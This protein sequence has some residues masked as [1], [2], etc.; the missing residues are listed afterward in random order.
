VSLGHW[1]TGVRALTVA[2]AL[3]AV[4]AQASAASTAWHDG[5]FDVQT[6]QVV[7]RSDVILAAP[8]TA[9]AD[10]LDLGNGR[11]GAAAW[12]PATGFHAQLNRSDTF[13][14]RPS[15]GWLI[16]PGLSAMTTAPDFSSRLDLYDGV[17]HESG[18]GMTLT[19]YMRSDKDELVVDV[20]GANPASTQ[21]A[22]IVNWT[23]T[24]GVKPLSRSAG[25][26]IATISGV[27][28]DNKTGV[29]TSPTNES[30]GLGNSGQTF[31]MLAAI[32]AGGR[33]VVAS[34]P[35]SGFP[36]GSPTGASSG[37]EV[38]FNPLADG[39]YRIV[40]GAPHFAGPTANAQSAAATLLAAD[41]SAPDASLRSATTAW[42]NDFW[43]S[44]DL[45]EM[46]GAD[47]SAGYLE[48]L[49]LIELYITAAESRDT[50]PGG[51]AGVADLFDYA[52]DERAW[53]P[54]GWWFWN[55]RME[56]QANLDAGA[57]SLD[58]TV[59]N[60]YASNLANLETMT[61]AQLPG[62]PGACTPE[63]MR[64]NGNGYAG[65]YSSRYNLQGGTFSFTAP[66]CVAGGAGSWNNRTVTSGAEISLWMW[67]QY[68]YTG[69]RTVLDRD[70]AYMESGARF[71]LSY[72]TVGGV[73]GLLHTFPSNAHETQ[74]DVHDPTTDIAAMS[75]LFPVV[76]QAAQTLGRDPLL[77]TQLTA[78]ETQIEPYARGMASSSTTLCNLPFNSAPAAAER[79]AAASCD[80]AAGD[81]IGNSY[82][83]GAALHNSE[84]LG[85]EPVWPY[86]LIGRDTVVDGDDL[87]QLAL[88]TFANRP[89]RSTGGGSQSNTDW[90]YDPLD[91]ARLGDAPDFLATIE[92]NTT[93]W[94]TGHA[95]GMG[96]SSS[97]GEPFLEQIGV[98][99]A[100]I[101][102]ALV[103]DYDGV[104][105]I[106][107]A[108]PTSTWN[109]VSGSVHIPGGSRVDVQIQG[110]ALET[111][112]IEA[113]SAGSLVIDNPWPGHAVEVVSGSDE[114]TQ[115]LA[116]TTASRFTLAVTA[117]RT[118]L[119]QQVGDPVSAMAVEPVGGDAN[120]AAKQ[121]LTH[122]NVYIGKPGTLRAASVAGAPL[123]AY[124]G[125]RFDGKVATVT[126][127]AD[128][129]G[130]ALSAGID[131]G[132]GS[133]A[134][135]GT[136]T[137]VLDAGG[138]RT[139][140]YAV[141]GSHTYG[142][143]GAVTVA[144][145]LAD[146]VT[147]A[148]VA[149]GTAA[150]SVTSAEL[151][152]TAAAIAATAGAAFSGPVATF[153]D[154]NASEPASSFAATID[155]GD[156]SG[157]STGV[158]TGGAGRFSVAGNHAF[159]APGSFPVSVTITDAG[160]DQASATVSSSAVV[161][162]DSTSVHVAVSAPQAVFGD[163]LT[164]SATVSAAGGA[165][166][167][168]TLQFYADG[169]PLG[170]AQ[171][172]S[173]GSASLTTASLVEAWHNLTAT[174]APDDA[175]PHMAPAASTTASA[176]V[177]AP[178]TATSVSSSSAHSWSGLPVTLTATVSASDGS[179]PSG[180]VQ[181]YSGT[182]AIGSPVAVT[183]GVARLTTGALPA[184]SD[185]VTAG[186]AST[187]PFNTT[188]SCT[189]CGN[190]NGWSSS[191]S[192][193]TNVV[194][195]VDSTPPAVTLTSPADGATFTQGRPVT[196]AYSC[197][198]VD[199]GLADCA[200]PLPSGA[201]LDTGTPGDYA[202]T[203]TAHDAVGN[204]TV[205][206]HHFRVLPAVNT[207][208]DVGGVVGSTL[209]LT[210]GA[211]ASFGAFT[212]G[213]AKDYAAAMTATVVSTAGDATLSVADPAATAPGHLVNGAFSLPS[214]LQVQAT[215][216]AGTG[217]APAPLGAAAL[218][219]LSYA[220]PVSNDP[221]T[222]SFQQHI[223]A[224]DALRTGG[225]GKT[226]TFTLSTTAP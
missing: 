42:W 160:G 121:F 110:G 203:V 71:L 84:N 8:N 68:L 122:A 69:D 7:S 97:A 219:L 94:Q 109:S 144:I 79:V 80:A 18:G 167:T 168:G 145:T 12:N 159:G 200:G 213:L 96:S 196:V 36:S 212:P 11:V 188:A 149:T 158:V 41:A 211:P 24:S 62:H 38:S 201:A 220:L 169:A 28:S 100:A 221:V 147:G 85:L 35:T 17:L 101:D 184:G 136:L 54:D 176:W 209:A 185:G 82:D 3:L 72:T 163:S 25:G 74:W 23:E 98:A 146:A 177:V 123:S 153:A 59:F 199:S 117:G 78:A 175:S 118:Y 151:A 105:R 130:I 108:W 9:A 19:A 171:T 166:P 202:F 170:A 63:T 21:T 162:L 40:V 89:Q 91:A 46:G 113:G 49:R 32:T 198:D 73:D 183:A 190:V 61:R 187:T 55:Q 70:Y 92:A 186:Y 83:L 124:A 14:F 86:N 226:L 154:S 102:E 157:P 88:R 22:W 52:Q 125:A 26:S 81:V 43:G 114:T 195:Q 139:G 13:P 56:I 204:Q 33:N 115:A 87:T 1:T 140:A 103:Q 173:G 192:G 178:V 172:V 37:A 77:V 141:S 95:Q 150:A 191:L 193:Q 111:V 205:V 155:W 75:A 138:A 104:L 214:P 218:A 143:A 164:V 161:V 112:A 29:G 99:A 50:D 207:S 44:V 27:W 15:P 76:I 194:V 51:Q 129:S 134:S 165:T 67:Q 225:Y 48:N 116:P 197:S 2:A 223:A 107:P 16:V 34:S 182:T 215:S 10:S 6:R 180:A 45:F 5:R 137:P 60:L 20:T 57:F 224:T 142:A 126:V 181:F 148:T 39:S 90:N 216:P 93:S 4:P 210:L 208:G 217:S 30:S 133:T 174:F 152:P 119:L 53:Q 222:V 128:A 206:T 31:G 64:F 156:G 132:D 106:A 66:Y 120:T 65:A 179:T 127:P 189:S 47:N 58:N 135:T 131:W